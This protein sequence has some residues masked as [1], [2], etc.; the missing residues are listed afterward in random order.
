MCVHS[1]VA[2]SE[3]RR[4]TKGNAFH[5]ILSPQPGVRVNLSKCRFITFFRVC[6][7]HNPFV[8]RGGD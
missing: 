8:E 2:H 7:E 1:D 3:Q 6:A 4:M 5:T